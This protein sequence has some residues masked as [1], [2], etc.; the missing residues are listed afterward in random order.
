MY[1]I[2]EKITARTLLHSSYIPD[3][4][5]G[6]DAVVVSEIIENDKGETRPNLRVF[7]SPEVSFWI[8]QPQHRGHTDKKEFESLQFLDEKIVRFKDKDKE[9]FRALNGFYP[10]FLTPN[11]RREIYQ[12]PYLYGGNISLEAK[13]AMKYKKDL[14]KA[15]RVSHT[16]TTG[17]FDIE[18]SLLPSSYGRLP[19]MVFTA[20][21]QVYLACKKSFMY[22]ERDGKTVPVT[23]QD[24]FKG[25]LEHIN[26][27]VA[28]IF[29]GTDDLND[30]KNRL[31]FD[32]HL[33][34]GETE[35][36]MIRWIFGKMHETKVSFIGI[37]NLG[38]DIPEI[39]KVLD[40]NKIPHKEIISDPTLLK[41]GY[42]HANYRE[43][44]RKVQH[45][46]QK[47]HW[48]TATA[49]FQFVDSMGLYSY[50][51]TVDGKETSYA[52]DDILKKFGLGGKL[53]IGQTQALD[54]LQT[55]DWHRE[56]L[57]KHFLSY[58]LYAMWDGISLQILEWLN[59][60]LTAM[61]LL[62]DTTPAKFF[63]N[64]TIRVTNTLFSD[65]FPKGYVVGTG[66][67]VEGIRDDDLLN[68]GG[69]VLEPQHLVARGLKLFQ[70]WPTHHTHCYA[71]QN[72][73]DFAGQYPFA[74]MVT[75]IS[76]QTKI[77]TMV[78]INAEWVNK[79]YD[80]QAAVEVL[81]SYLV[82]PEASGTDLGI[83]FFNLP[84]Y[85]EMAQLFDETMAA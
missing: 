69:A 71:W 53:K 23:L 34:E 68:E 27:L 3:I 39:L 60:D 84:D 83:E 21:N 45:F 46:T 77:A 36:D 32:Y 12:S 6:D 66:V 78:K 13:V 5:N 1:N 16:P 80:P 67:D 10:N 30:Y 49:H 20:E 26:P 15:N 11:Q 76:K 29:A 47:W 2:A 58:A 51:R 17:F 65:W 41:A 81:G 40:E 55:E 74:C 4:G 22:E 72:D 24:I 35:V 18:K 37:W 63:P 28:S 82:T 7:K 19:L 85:A 8:T 48:L 61:M 54:D 43:D 52:L 64:Q 59:N 33:F 75:N 73:F 25:A 14:L 38:F 44:K 9:I 79:R 42:S 70:E 62:G 50:I 31:P 56:M 57:S